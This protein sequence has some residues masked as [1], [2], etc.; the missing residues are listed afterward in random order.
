MVL[1]LDSWLKIFLFCITYSFNMFLNHVALLF[2]KVI[3]NQFWLFSDS[4]S[5]LFDA[6]WTFVAIFCL[7]NPPQKSC[8]KKQLQKKCIKNFSSSDKAS[9]WS[10][11][12]VLPFWVEKL[13]NKSNI[14]KRVQFLGIFYFRLWRP[15]WASDLQTQTKKKIAQIVKITEIFAVF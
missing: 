3:L 9:F 11:K 13:D 1:G 14:V 12:F 2:I 4:I 5:V 8:L 6:A 15:T 7:E 10:S